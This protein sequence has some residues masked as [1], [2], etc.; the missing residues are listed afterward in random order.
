MKKTKQQKKN[1]LICGI[2][3][4]FPFIIKNEIGKKKSEIIMRKD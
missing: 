3:F 4:L 1:Y 2:T